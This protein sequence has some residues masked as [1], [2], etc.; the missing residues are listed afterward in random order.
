MAASGLVIRFTAIDAT[1]PDIL[2]RRLVLP[3][4][5]DDFGF[6]ETAAWENYSTVAAGDFS[7]PSAGGPTERSL[8]TVDSLQVMTVDF[9]AAWLMS[10]ISQADA[11][12]QL[13]SILRYKTPFRFEASVRP[14]PGYAELEMDAKLTSIN[15]TLRGGLA[16]ARYWALGVEE[17]RPNKIDRRGTHAPSRGRGG[18]RLPTSHKL[19]VNETMS[20]LASHYY[21]SPAQWRFIAEA[22][23]I[24]NWGATTPLDQM[25][26]FKVGDKILIPEKP[27]SGIL[28][29]LGNAPL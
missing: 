8:R 9:D 21:G 4:V 25:K 29:D 24:R 3:C 1:H 18:S 23:G 10:R 7:V 14:D 20:T 16:S 5:T 2:R 27:G 11:R 15:R 13:S 26:R 17:W 19:A 22:N 6:T 28:P 12:A